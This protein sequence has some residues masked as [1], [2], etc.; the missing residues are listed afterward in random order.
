MVILYILYVREIIN[1]TLIRKSLNYLG[2]E[3]CISTKQPNS[4]NLEFGCILYLFVSY[5][6]CIEKLS[7]EIIVIKTFIMKIKYFFVH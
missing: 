6:I 5:F 4:C 1:N 7:V 3:E 2:N